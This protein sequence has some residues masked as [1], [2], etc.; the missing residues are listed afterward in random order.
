VNEIIKKRF[1]AILSSTIKRIDRSGTIISYWQNYQNKQERLFEETLESA[2]PIFLK[3]PHD[4]QKPFIGLVK[5]SPLWDASWPKYERFLKAN[6]IPYAF[7][8][9]HKSDFIQKA[10]SFDVI[11]WTTP[12]NFSAQYEAKSKITLL[13][14]HLG[15]ICIPSSSEIWYYEDKAR[16]NWLFEINNVPS[17]KTFVS[18]SKSEALI[19][20]KTT[21]YP[22]ISKEATNSGSRGVIILKNQLQARKFCTQ[23][24]GPGRRIISSTY[25]RQ[26]NYVIFQEF[27]PNEGY[28]LRVY[29]IGNN[30]LGIY[31][32]VPKGDFRASGGG[33]IVKKDIPRE[34]LLFAKRVKESLPPSLYLSVDLL[35]STIDN[36]YYVTEVSRFNRTKDSERLV[37]NGVPGKYHY[38]DGNFTFIPGRF[39]LQEL[40]LEEFFHTYISQNLE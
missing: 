25:L 7:Y 37:V 24:F 29:I 6:H 19:F 31:R 2:D 8:D 22:I 17:I 36:Q 14:K 1:L 3:W 30:F 33:L 26:K 12:S 28:D 13:E 15:K 5:D 18:F 16:Q 20:I 35:K 10:T 11:I 39:W 9:I 23:V 21:N 40:T 34:A 4:L 38:K 27:L 32:D